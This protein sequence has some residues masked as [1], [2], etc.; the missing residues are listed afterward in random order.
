[1][2]GALTRDNVER[3]EL[4]RVTDCVCARERQY[5]VDGEKYQEKKDKESKN[6]W[7]IKVEVLDIGGGCPDEVSVSGSKAQA[8]VT[9]FFLVMNFKY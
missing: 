5:G 9:S 2:Q 7:G 6:M 8:P 3:K 1:M 4:F